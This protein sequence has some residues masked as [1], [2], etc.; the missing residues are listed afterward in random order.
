MQSLTIVMVPPSFGR[1]VVIET[2]ALPPASTVNG[3]VGATVGVATSRPM[4]ATSTFVGPE[5]TK[6][7]VTRFDEKTIRSVAEKLQP[8]ELPELPEPPLD[9]LLGVLPTP[10]L[11]PLLAGL[12]T[13]LETGL[14]TAELWG[15]PLEVFALPD[16]RSSRG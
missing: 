9:P 11:L 8:V 16:I 12:D 1:T 6:V 14:L 7:K 2:P 4:S 10:P 15:T 13:G 3:G 5:L